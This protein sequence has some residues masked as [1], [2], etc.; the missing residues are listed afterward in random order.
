MILVT[1][2]AGKTGNAVVRAL[3]ARKADVR[4]LVRRPEQAASL[5]ALGVAEVAIGSFGDPRALREAAAGA[6]AIY[7][8]CPNVS[9]EEFRFAEAVVA[10]AEAN[11]IRR[12]VYHSVLHPQIEAMPHHWQKRKVE[13]MLFTKD[14]ELTILQPTAYMQNIF[15]AWR[16]SEQDDVL[17]FP[18]PVETRISLVD[19]EDVAEA[20]ALVLTNDGHGGATYELAGTAPLSQSEVAATIGAVLG[21]TIRVEAET[22][23]AWAARA[24]DA[25]MN[26]YAR[27]ALTAMFRYYAQHGLVGNCNTLGW[28]LGRAPGDLARFARR[29]K[30]R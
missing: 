9:P 2:A 14:F 12:F 17:R 22:I 24:G 28:L 29:W 18:Y 30:A 6:H 23:D 3:V 20:A 27:V 8:I 5:E 15:G 13:E 26:S 11:R 19:L 21:K 10:A 4:G 1:G 7:H 16:G 25:G